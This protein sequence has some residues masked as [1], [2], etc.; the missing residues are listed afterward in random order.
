[1]PSMC[2]V[3]THWASN[4]SSVCNKCS[5]HLTTRG[6]FVAIG[7]QLFFY[8]NYPNFVYA[9]RCLTSMIVHV[10][11]NEQYYYMDNNGYH[12]KYIFS[13]MET[14]TANKNIGKRHNRRLITYYYTQTKEIIIMPIIRA[15]HFYD[16]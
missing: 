16:F 11:W 6:V 13:M 8:G 3:I 12:I 9:Q 1:M 7:K 14:D 10:R 2:S 15:L 5:P 4:I